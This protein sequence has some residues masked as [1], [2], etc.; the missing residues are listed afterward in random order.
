MANKKKV[1]VEIIKEKKELTSTTEKQEM[2]RADLQLANDYTRLALEAPMS[3][4]SDLKGVMKEMNEDS[5]ETEAK[6]PSI[7][8]RTRL[9]PFEITNIVIH[10]TIISLDCLPKDCL[11][12]TRTKKRLAV[13]ESGKGRSEMVQIV[14]GERDKQSSGGFMS[15]VKNMF[16]PKKE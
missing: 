7:D 5:L 3:Q 11:I 13:S 1:K 2:T 6:L 8:M 16:A 14:Q 15:T 12:T 4:D 9:H 10:D